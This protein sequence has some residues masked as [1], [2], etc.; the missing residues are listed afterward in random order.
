M[1]HG[2]SRNNGF[3]GNTAYN[4]GTMWE[5]FETMLQPFVVLT[6]VIANRIFRACL[7]GDG[8]PQ[9]DEVTRLGEV[10]C[11]SRLLHDRWGDPSRVTSPT[12][13]PARPCKQA[14]SLALKKKLKAS[15]KWPVIDLGDFILTLVGQR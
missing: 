8:G 7:H 2:T 4:I 11:L 1:L 3:R 10:T 13:G 12:W 6:I 5:L 9:E 14:L 15:R